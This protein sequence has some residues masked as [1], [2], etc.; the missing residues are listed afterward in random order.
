MGT[1]LALAGEANL[2]DENGNMPAIN[3][4]FVVDSIAASIGPLGGVPS[5]TA[6][7]ESAAGVE[8][9]GRTG[10]TAIF[11]AACFALMLFFGPVILMVPRVATSPALILVGMSMFS[12]LRKIDLKD[13][14]AAFPALLAVLM[15]LYAN[16]FG[17]GI[18]AGILG[19]V[20]VQVLAGRARQVS[21]SLY[22]LSIP[23]LYFFWTVA[24]RH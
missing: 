13:F 9:G 16:N 6:L 22:L 14:A 7:I 19:Y 2:L 24:A 1:T 3:G 18:A 21:L 15:T 8:A 12:N 5:A 11:A 4:P 10:L 23:L 20:G 17:T